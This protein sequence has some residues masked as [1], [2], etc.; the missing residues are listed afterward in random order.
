MVSQ[1]ELIEY[2]TNELKR[3]GF[4]KKAKRWTKTK[5][6][7]T[8]VFFIQGSQWDREAYYIRPGVFIND[9]SSIS[10]YY[11]H[12][13]TEIAQ[14]SIEQIFADLNTFYNN[15]TDKTRIKKT[16]LDFFRWEE[17]NPLEKRRAGKVD[18]K[19]DPVPDPVMF[20]VRPQVIDYII[21]KY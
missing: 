1:S 17:R 20:A 14:E 10:D 2:A 4:R 13:H 18:Y 9:L 6:D 21:K 12:F 19:S 16:V 11:G 7:F 3:Q 8:L 5:N 15:W